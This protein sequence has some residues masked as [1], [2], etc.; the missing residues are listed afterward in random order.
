MAELYFMA[1][2]IFAFHAV[3]LGLPPY[4]LYRYLKKQEELKKTNQN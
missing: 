1:I 4:L 3:V 2:S